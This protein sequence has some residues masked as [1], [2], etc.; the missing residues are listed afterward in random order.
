MLFFDHISQPG[1]TIALGMSAPRKFIEGAGKV[2]SEANPAQQKL[3]LKD[4][5]DYVGCDPR[6]L[7]F[8]IGSSPV[9]DEISVPKFYA[10]L[11]H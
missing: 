3:I 8:M 10:P 11:G 4:I 6:D 1:L 9:G 7:D 2:L 5:A